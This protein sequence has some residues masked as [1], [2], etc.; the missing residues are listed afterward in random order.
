MDSSY[1]DLE[2][3]SKGWE[4]RP[5]QDSAEPES[6]KVGLMEIPLFCFIVVFLSLCFIAMINSRHESEI[7]QARTRFKIESAQ[8]A[9]A[10]AENIS[11]HFKRISQD[12]RLI[13]SIPAL[14][15]FNAASATLSEDSKEI[16]EQLFSNIQ[17]EGHVSE[18]HI[19]YRNQKAHANEI[20]APSMT[21]DQEGLHFEQA[22]GNTSQEV[23]QE[24]VTINEQLQWL[25]KSLAPE[26]VTN[27]T[28]N[29]TSI[30]GK[31]NSIH[32]QK[33]TIDRASRQS[34][35]LV[36]SVPLLATN[37]SVL[38][39]VSAIISVNN[40][41]KW[42]P[43]GDYA[44]VNP[45]LNVNE[46]NGEPG[47]AKS[48]YER[49]NLG[50][51]LESSA[52]S[53][54]IPVPI[55]SNSNNWRVWYAIPAAK[56]DSRKDV[57]VSNQF[58]G[59]SILAVTIFS[60]LMFACAA[61]INHNR[62]RLQLINQELENEVKS[63]TSKLLTAR[64]MEAI[65][66]LAAGV[67]H[68]INTPSQF[69]G[70]NLKF[71]QSSF[72]KLTKLNDQLRNWTAEL[73]QSESKE[74]ILD[75]LSSKS[76]ERLISEVPEAILESEQGVSRIKDIVRSL[77]DFAHPGVNDLSQAD[78]NRI[79]ESSVTVARNEWKYV[80]DLKLDLRPSLPSLRCHPGELGQLVVI[81]VVN[82][83]HAIR[84][85]DP[86]G[87]SG[88][89]EVKTEYEGDFLELTIS[90]NG[91]GIPTE[92][93]HRIFDQ[94]FTT[95]EIGVGTGLGLSIAQNIVQRHHGTLKF[96]TKLGIGTKF[97]IRLPLNVE[98]EELD[99]AA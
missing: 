95:K 43:S 3:T 47:L 32:L 45:K 26:A 86:E 49:A 75:A 42:L 29:L 18:V 89:I 20:I 16:L 40:V 94:F 64:K 88:V 54:S 46:T 17:R 37:G 48:T 56:F 97:I 55:S 22:L 98:P 90:D 41:T 10:V 27:R 19:T 9:A 83:A 70:D 80:A 82:A 38:G 14:R 72:D 63:R 2:V 78:L 99:E 93:Q 67:A 5:G 36:V 85:R 76:L 87:K 4:Y 24:F 92:I 62:R 21:L 1:V 13:G 7:N 6:P 50:Q 30:S 59:V 51:Q 84:E 74:Q 11:A 73:P 8:N 23:S 58:M 60:C 52:V 12:I 96:E 61:F 53:G 39:C 81:L 57:E 33:E 77:R 79:I 66:Q 44:L 68:E 34:D 69:I 25:E 28:T 15:H 91:S 35:G 71:L 65:G 31:L